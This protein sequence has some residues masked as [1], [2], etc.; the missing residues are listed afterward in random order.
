[1]NYLTIF[2][3][4][5][6]MA[7]I[8]QQAAQPAPPQLPASVEGTVIRA[9]SAPP[10]PIARA[11]VV[12]SSLPRGIAETTLLTVL[13]DEAGRFVLRDIPPGAYN[14]MATRDGFVK[15]TKPITLVP[16][17]SIT[18]ALL[19]LTPTGAIA[20]RLRDRAG[21][22]VSNGLVQAQRYTYR[23]GRR[24]LSNVQR[25][26]TNDLGEFRLFFLPP[27][28]YVL[29][30]LP[31][32][33]PTASGGPGN[34][35]TLLVRALPGVPVIGNLLGG[36][37]EPGQG[38]IRASIGEFL[39]AGIVPAS[40]TG[41]AEAPVYFP[42]TLDASAATPIDL[43][44]GADFRNADFV[45]TEARASR[46][47]GQV[48]NGATGLP[49][50]GAQVMLISKADSGD[51]LPGRRGVSSKSDGTF[52]FAGV[53]PGSYDLAAMV[54]ALPRD[55]S[56]GGS[57]LPGGA[58][59]NP[60]PPGRN[61][62]DFSVD[63][64]EMRLAA[65]VPIQI[66]GSDIE[67]V[68]LTAERGHTIRGRLT[69]DGALLEETQ[70]QITGVVVQ[71][72]PTSDDFETAAMPAPVRPDG[73]FTIVG[74]L[75]GTYRIWLMGATNMQNGLVYVKSAM[76]G[77]VD[78]INPRFVIEKEPVGDLEI[79]VST[80]TGRVSASVVDA[81][82]GEPAAG[83]TVVLIPD[84]TRRQHYDLYRGSPT[85]PTGTAGLSVPPGDYTA[86]AFENIEPNSWWDPLVM[87]KY[88]GQGTPVRVDAGGAT[89]IRL[90]AIR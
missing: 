23:E 7:A 3:L 75:P 29:S 71:L 24:T 26:I 43:A 30:A 57:G 9:G 88:A 86:Y 64:T 63:P 40:T 15:A 74:A 90:R 37:D 56:S 54:G 11:R 69:V 5:L 48:V 35:A 60:G 65:R 62:R 87:Q 76:L 78:V 77:P 10:A 84:S 42:G 58:G 38:M 66:A 25:A 73:T 12:L 45:V 16:R 51:L 47:R 82:K 49:A 6:W 39:S 22:P 8:P 31:N 59:I 27:G 83:V 4:A 20:G 61:P 81:V 13:T 67:N 50:G 52:E 53:P 33:G 44:P 32:T 1:M 55:I 80:A 89:S 46:I 85:N 17:D 36:R 68:V 34:D 19:E 2:S 70:R 18:N 79:V 41:A 14:L 21:N 28:Q 72:M